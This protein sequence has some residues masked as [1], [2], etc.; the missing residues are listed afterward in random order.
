MQDF[1]IY[2]ST[3]DKDGRIVDTCKGDSGGPLVL[4]R[5]GGWELVGVLKVVF[6]FLLMDFKLSFFHRGK[7][8]IAQQTSQGA[9]GNGAMWRFSTDGSSARFLWGEAKVQI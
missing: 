3:R 4:W 1:W 2:T 9:M 6:P 7:V 5:N 8:L